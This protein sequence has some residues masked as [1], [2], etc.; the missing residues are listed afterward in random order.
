MGK[1]AGCIDGATIEIIEQIHA[2]RKKTEYGTFPSQKEHK[3]F[4]KFVVKRSKE[5]TTKKDSIA[6]HNSR[7]NVY[8]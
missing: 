3:E 7:L 5:L 4:E 8:Y 1:P 6:F 2:K